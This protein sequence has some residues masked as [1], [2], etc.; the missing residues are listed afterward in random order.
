MERGIIASPG[1]MI[2]N[3]NG[4]F[5]ISGNLS[6]TDINYFLLY[7]DKIV[8]PDNNIFG[9]DLSYLE[10]LIRYNIIETP[11]VVF[12]YNGF[13]DNHDFLTISQSITAN[14]LIKNDKRADWTIHQFGDQIS[15]M[16][17]DSAI[18]KTI[19]FEILNALPV[20]NKEVSFEEVLNF[21]ESR[22]SEL[23]GLHEILDDL[24][25]EI[26]KSPD[27]DFATRKGI[28]DLRQ[29]IEDLHK[30]TKE[31]FKFFSNYNRTTDLNLNIKTLGTGIGYGYV[32]D[33]ITGIPLLGA[34]GVAGALVNIK[35]TQ[36]I[37]VEAA[38][39][40]MKLN[41]LSSASRE[42]IIKQVRR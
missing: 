36:T 3:L 24:Y 30:V 42:G 32:I 26:L 1:R 19:R 27:K 18:F 17:K 9:I 6:V 4:S 39:S 5:S 34:L 14:R 37:G 38:K 21:K 35:L 23:M 25:I 8:I 28:S 10:E 11:R 7:F 29:S 22:K 16:G 33:L 20:P 2:R 13:I 15:L 41:Y 40:K 31:R 12:K